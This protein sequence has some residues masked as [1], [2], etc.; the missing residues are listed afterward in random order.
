MCGIVGL[1]CNDAYPDTA[2]L[3]TS[4]TQALYHRGPDDGSVAAFGLG[5]QPVTTRV[6][7]RPG[8]PV[9][10]GTA[11]ASLALGVRR[12][13]I[14][15]RS[16]RGR[17]PMSADGGNAWIAFNGEIY[18]HVE[19]RGEL[20]ARGMTFAGDS[21]TEV[22]L[23]AYRAWGPACLERLRGMWAMAV[24]DWVAGR[25]VLSRDR[26]GIK[27]LY[28]A[29][30]DRGY[31]FASEI[32]ALLMLPGVGRGVNEARLR[33]FLVDGRIDHT[34]T[35]LFEDVWS[36]EA[37][38]WLEIDLRPQTMTAMLGRLHRYWRGAAEESAVGAAFGGAESGR[39]RELVDDSLKMHLR[40]DVPVGSCLSGGLD[41][42]TIVAS[43]AC[44]AGGAVGPRWSQHTFSAVLPGEPMDEA[45]YADAI[46]AAYPG[47]L[48]HRVVPTAERLLADLDRLVW[49]QEEPFGSPSVFM[50]WE[51]M[52]LAR[53]AGVPVLLDGQGGDE[54]FGGYPGYLPPYLASLLMRLHGLRAA[55]EGLAAGWRGHFTRAG[56][57]IHTVGWML[58]RGLRASLR[59]RAGRRRATFLDPELLEAEEPAVTPYRLRVPRGSGEPDRVAGDV[60]TGFCW[61][62]LVRNSLPAL[63]HFEDRSSMAFSIEARVPLLDAPLVDYALRLPPGSKLRAGRTKVVLREA[64]R[65]RVPA[66]IL[67]RTDKIGFAAP[68]VSWMRGSLRPWWRDLIGSRSFRDRGCFRPRAVER[69]AARL[70]G[71]AESAAL[72]MWRM[73]IVEQWARRMLDRPAS[74]SG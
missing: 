63:L 34:T 1:I 25:V 57:A 30:F 69:L 9:E 20:A 37:G 15:D 21:D 46:Q 10:W 23:V 72:P 14:I 43:L 31:A 29:A 59:G 42:S 48:G 71:G 38:C 6:L 54:L 56:L 45:A 67:D 36:L 49:H 44:L 12:L 50:Q 28:L 16:I 33:D 7:G 8:E 64:M 2:G 65:G 35:T 55:S 58:P 70:E 62:T 40:S 51:V 22:A 68:T 26:L 73:A 60:F 19:L 11:R 17:Q 24:V 74:S 41:S 18:N 4:L 13:A 27:P 66:T 39:V 52:R 32:K 5:G 3:C 61:E 53:E 47:L